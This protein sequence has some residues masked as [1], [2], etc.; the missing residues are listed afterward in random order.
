[1]TTLPNANNGKRKQQTHA[2]F[3]AI[4]KRATRQ[5]R[6]GIHFLHI[7]GLPDGGKYANKA[8]DRQEVADIT[9]ISQKDSN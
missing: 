1:M 5:G 9:T 4:H 2:P 6:Y 3:G 8:G 7:V